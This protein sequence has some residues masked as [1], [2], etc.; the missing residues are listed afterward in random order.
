MAR[1]GE[2]DVHGNWMGGYRPSTEKLLNGWNR[3]DSATW[4]KRDER[5]ARC[6]PAIQRINPCRGEGLVIRELQPSRTVAP[7]GDASNASKLENGF[8]QRDRAVQIDVCGE[9]DARTGR[10]EIGNRDG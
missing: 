9:F 5:P 1:E 6:K 4:L 10:T 8:N 2:H 3:R 7:P